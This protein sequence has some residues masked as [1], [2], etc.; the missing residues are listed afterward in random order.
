MSEPAHLE[1][2]GEEAVRSATDLLADLEPGADRVS[3]W[4]AGARAR[5]NGELL[6]TVEVSEAKEA[7]IGS[8]E[9]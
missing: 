3:L 1:L 8:D 4:L 9:I 2:W 7:G 5:R 6:Y